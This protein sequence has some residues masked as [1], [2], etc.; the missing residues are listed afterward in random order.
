[1]E[2]LTAKDV[3]KLANT[4]KYFAT[5]VKKNVCV[6]VSEEICWGNV[7]PGMTWETQENTRV[8][9]PC[10]RTHYA[11]TRKEAIALATKIQKKQHVFAV[12]CGRQKDFNDMGWWNYDLKD[13]K[14]ESNKW[15]YNWNV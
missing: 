13:K 9:N 11:T 8:Q 5:E 10:F 4:C 1:M 6:V 2:Y 15:F 7:K 12:K 3:A 14:R